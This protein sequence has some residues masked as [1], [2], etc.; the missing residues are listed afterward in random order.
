MEG[1]EM[2][3]VDNAEDKDKKDEKPPLPVAKPAPPEV[4]SGAED[5][6]LKP[7]TTHVGI[8]VRVE[9]GGI[10]STLMVPDVKAG[11]V[12]ITKPV[13]LDGSKLM[14]YLNKKADL[15]LE[16]DKAPG[17][18]IGAT[19]IS[20]QAFYVRTNGPLLMMFEVSFDK[21]DKK[22]LIHALTGDEDLGS[23]FEVKGASLRLMRCSKEGLE[24]LKKYAAEL[25]Q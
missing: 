11:I 19:T 25:S 7:D 6:D 22:G 18:L 10:P 9:S 15:K 21:Q 24:E 2:T 23:L 17:S 8:A 16:A 1:P 5:L 3:P 20:C 12:Y 13:Q 14:A 4:L